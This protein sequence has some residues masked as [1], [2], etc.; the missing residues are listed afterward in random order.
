[1]VHPPDSRSED[2]GCTATTS[3]LSLNRSGIASQDCTHA[4]LWNQCSWIRFVNADDVDLQTLSW[5]LR[6]S[7]HLI[8]RDATELAVWQS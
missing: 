3:L 8:D 5:R 7:Q 6:W 2:P 1:M 4:S